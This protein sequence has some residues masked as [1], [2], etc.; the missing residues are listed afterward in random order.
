[1]IVGGR[2]SL[3]WHRAVA[4]MW[5]PDLMYRG[6]GIPRSSSKKK[7]KEDKKYKEYLKHRECMKQIQQIRGQQRKFEE[8]EFIEHE[9]EKGNSCIIN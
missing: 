9:S 8:F 2:L 6:L 3:Q 4:E 7:Q 5:K 1:M